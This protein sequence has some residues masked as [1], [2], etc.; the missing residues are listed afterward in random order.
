MCM[1]AP[2]MPKIPDPIPPP[3]APPPAVKTAKSVGNKTLKSR[4]TGKKSGTSGLT[5]RRSSTVNT[6]SSGSGA[7]VS[8]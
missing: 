4:S 2:K 1:S 3:M 7:N 6:G 5:V 8:Y